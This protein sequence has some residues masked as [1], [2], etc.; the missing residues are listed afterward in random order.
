MLSKPFKL[1]ENLE[2]VGQ[3]ASSH[4]DMLTTL[5]SPHYHERMSRQLKKKLNN[6]YHRGG[7]EFVVRLNPNIFVDEDF[8]TV[9][10][11]FR[12]VILRFWGVIFRF[13]R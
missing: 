12:A 7:A 5:L 9:I 6:I 4:S 11:W 1:S 3:W 13:R 2:G 10:F 8:Y